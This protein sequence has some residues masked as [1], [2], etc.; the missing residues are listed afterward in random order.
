MYNYFS[1]SLSL[2]SFSSSSFSFLSFSVPKPISKSFPYLR[3]LYPSL[4]LFLYFQPSL[5]FFL[6][7]SSSSSSS[8]SSSSSSSFSSFFFFFFF[9]LS[10][11]LIQFCSCLFYPLSALSSSLTLMLFLSLP[12]SLSCF[13]YF[14]L[15]LSPSPPV[16]L[17]PFFINS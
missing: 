9:F 17:F 3:S 16:L 4:A 2:T 15:S 1:L 7:P 11:F 13:R 5:S 6:S 8:F 12:C 10:Q 14:S